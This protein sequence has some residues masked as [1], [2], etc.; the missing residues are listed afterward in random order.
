MHVGFRRLC[1]RRKL[2]ASA[3]NQ[4]V[5][6]KRRHDGKN[7]QNKKRPFIP[8][9]TEHDIPP[10]AA[11]LEN[12]VTH[13]MTRLHT[14]K[15]DPS[16][17]LSRSAGCVHKDAAA[18]SL[19]PAKAYRRHRHFQQRSCLE[20]ATAWR[21]QCPASYPPQRIRPAC[22]VRTDERIWSRA[23]RSRPPSHRGQD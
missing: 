15:L 1:R 13:R 11:E 10:A 8:L 19:G 5:N 3:C 16:E 2:G 20:C 17:S 22:V 4:H 6:D 7:C 23:H 18:P 21:S 12:N 14:E 9:Q